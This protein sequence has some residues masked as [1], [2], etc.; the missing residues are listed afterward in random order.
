MIQVDYSLLLQIINF[1]LLIVIL[2][3]LLYKPMLAVID[4][5]KMR[6]ADSEGEISRLNTLAEEKMAAYEEKLRTTKME[7]VEKNKEII[8]E[9]LEEAKHIS[10]QAMEEIGRQSADFHRQLEQDINKARGFLRTQAE[11]LSFEIAGKA[12]GRRIQ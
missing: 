6:L 11:A 4:E 10:D 1:L 9:A 7:A 8:K 12:L 2:N 3:F 5:R